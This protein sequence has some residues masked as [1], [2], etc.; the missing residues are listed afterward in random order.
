MDQPLPSTPSFSNMKTNLDS[1]NSNQDI[2]VSWKLLKW[3]FNYL[4]ET[5][6]GSGIRTKSGLVV[7]LDGWQN[8]P[9]TLPDSS[10][11]FGN[12]C[13][14]TIVTIWN[15]LPLTSPTITFLF[16]IFSRAS[17]LCLRKMFSLLAKLVVLIFFEFSF[18][19]KFQGR[20]MS[21]FQNVRTLS[22]MQN[23]ELMA[24]SQYPQTRTS[25]LKTGLLPI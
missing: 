15:A 13:T 6:P 20:D 2:T 18:A 23:S 12:D 5:L 14:V 10:E 1:N 17:S 24:G 8:P 11:I 9:N 19:A 7:F 4:T 16:A 21:L 22:Y 25:L 3:S